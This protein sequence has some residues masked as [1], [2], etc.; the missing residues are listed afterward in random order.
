MPVALARS[1]CKEASRK[2]RACIVTNRPTTTFCQ[3][4]VLFVSISRKCGQG[5]AAFLVGV[6][7]SLS[8]E[9]NDS[10]GKSMSGGR[11]VVASCRCRL[12]SESIIGNG[13]LYGATGDSG[14]H[15]MA[16]IV[17]VFGIRQLPWSKGSVYTREY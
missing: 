8:G 14:I 6:S 7:V 16:V 1:S 11:L 10:L 3:M 2:R 5:F 17:S 15:G 12:C 13:A 9:A 4:R